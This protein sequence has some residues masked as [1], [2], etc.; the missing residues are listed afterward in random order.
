MDPGRQDIVT[1]KVLSHPRFQNCELGGRRSPPNSKCTKKG[2]RVLGDRGIY[3]PQRARP[4][5]RLHCNG[6]MLVQ[7]ISSHL[8]A[9]LAGRGAVGWGCVRLSPH[10]TSYSPSPNAA[11]GKEAPSGS[12][13]LS[14]SRS[15][16]N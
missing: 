2:V 4:W 3:H 16:G 13:L 9:S 12:C 1:T 5:L 10:H 7:W 8:G 14:C 11:Y 6:V 15:D